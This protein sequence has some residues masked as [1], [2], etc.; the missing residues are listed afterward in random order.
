[1]LHLHLLQQFLSDH[2]EN[3]TNE[4]SLIIERLCTTLEVHTCGINHTMN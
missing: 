3:G 2:N 4:K 1:M